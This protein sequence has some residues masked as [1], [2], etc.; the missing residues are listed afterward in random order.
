MVVLSIREK[1]LIEMLAGVFASWFHGGWSKA[2]VN[3]ANSFM[4][5]QVNG[6]N[7]RRSLEAIR[8]RKG[9]RG[10]TRSSTTS[11]TQRCAVLI[12]SKGLLGFA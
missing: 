6:L 3:L 9:W 10:P 4:E 12:C 7:L 11:R 2:V 8:R 1:P 5:A